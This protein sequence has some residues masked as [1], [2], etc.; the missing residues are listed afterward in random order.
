MISKNSPKVNEYNKFFYVSY[1][2][3]DSVSSDKVF[4][5]GE[6]GVIC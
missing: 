1:S 5:M 6:M 2:F 3:D 4:L